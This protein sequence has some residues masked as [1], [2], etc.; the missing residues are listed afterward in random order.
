MSIY[1]CHVQDIIRKLRSFSTSRT[2]RL[3]NAFLIY[4]DLLPSYAA[5]MGLRPCRHGIPAWCRM[6]RPAPFMSVSTDRTGRLAPNGSR[7]KGIKNIYTCKTNPAFFCYGAPKVT[8]TGGMSPPRCDAE[9]INRRNIQALSLDIAPVLPRSMVCRRG[10]H[11]A[12]AHYLR[13]VL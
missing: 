8:A 3:V 11:R 12:A 4:S 13:W 7:C 6:R 5:I 10:I 2:K 9:T 1:R